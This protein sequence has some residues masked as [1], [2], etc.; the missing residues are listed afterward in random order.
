MSINVIQNTFKK[1]KRERKKN[2]IKTYKLLE[3][4]NLLINITITSIEQQLHKNKIEPFA[5][6]QFQMPK[7][8]DKN[9][10][11]K[12]NFLFSPPILSFSSILFPLLGWFSLDHEYAELPLPR[13]AN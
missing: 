9:M 4:N 7:R 8:N 1:K 6:F 10:R 12:K 13:I 5:Y 11:E 3:G 2:V